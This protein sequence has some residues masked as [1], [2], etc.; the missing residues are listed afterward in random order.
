MGGNMSEQKTVKVVDVSDELKSEMEWRGFNED[1]PE[2]NRHN[3]KWYDELIDAI[4][5]ITNKHY[6]QFEI[7]KF[8][9]PVDWFGRPELHALT[10]SEAWKHSFGGTEVDLIL[11]AKDAIET[12]DKL[13]NDGFTIYEF[14]IIIADAFN[15]DFEFKVKAVDD[16]AEVTSHYSVTKDIY[17]M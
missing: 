14:N 2:R 8:Y 11:Q 3:S 1:D 13:G 15:L 7:S 6:H 16:P 9:I 17:L 4:K 5:Y 10:T 12:L